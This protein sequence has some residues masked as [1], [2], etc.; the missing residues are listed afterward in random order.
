M[1][2]LP[3][4]NFNLSEIGINN[5][6]N[7]QRNQLVLRQRGKLWHCCH[8]LCKRLSLDAT[9]LSLLPQVTY[10]YW[11]C[12]SLLS[13]CL[14]LNPEPSSIKLYYSGST[15]KKKDHMCRRQQKG[16]YKF[17]CKWCQYSSLEKWTHWFPCKTNVLKRMQVDKFLQ[18]DTPFVFGIYTK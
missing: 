18:V 8:V 15:E 9:C 3:T 2:S 11:H 13:F 4:P 10:F 12:L 16:G 1:L 17:I 7:A 14:K 6:I 5:I